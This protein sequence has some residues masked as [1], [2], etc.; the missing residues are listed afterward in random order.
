MIF[1]PEETF[2]EQPED[3]GY[4]YEN[5]RVETADGVNLFGWFLHA[6]APEQGALLFLHGNAGNISNRLSKVKGWVDGGFSVFLIDY[7]GYGKSEGKINRSEDIV[8]DAQAGLQWLREEKKK[9]LSEIILYGE[10]LGSYPAVRLGTE[11][12]VLALVLESSFTSFL[13]LGRIHYPYVPKVL[14]R[15]F[16]FENEKHIAAV[17][18]PVFMLHGTE[19]EICPYS[20][21][22]QLFKK[23]PEPKEFFP[24]HGGNHNDLPLSAGKDFWRRPIEFILR[25]KP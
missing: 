7:R 19:D 13:D 20:L 25:N 17:R 8:L 6:K 12:P 14:L 24:I 15:R 4:A 18:S 21:S 3:Y 23:A 22:Q 10:S 1:F 16:E 9:P 2:Y 11:H 5:V